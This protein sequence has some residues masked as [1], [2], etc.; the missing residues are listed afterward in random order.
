MAETREAPAWFLRKLKAIEPRLT[1]VWR[2]HMKRWM[3]G[4]RLRWAIRG[5]V[6]DEKRIYHVNERLARV[7]YTPELGSTVLDWCRRNRIGRF[8]SVAQMV[9]ELQMDESYEEGQ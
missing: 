6:H 1:V 8:Q 4:E 3:V 5:P 9:K 7:F 2:P